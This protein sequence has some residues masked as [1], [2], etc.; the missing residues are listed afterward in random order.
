MAPPQRRTWPGGS[1]KAVLGRV[2]IR[3]IGRTNQPSKIQAADQL[4]D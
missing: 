2:L 3:K 1:C 4:L